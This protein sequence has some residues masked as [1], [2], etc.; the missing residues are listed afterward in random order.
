MVVGGMS[1]GV[2]ARCVADG[3]V[4]FRFP[5]FWRCIKASL[6]GVVCCLVCAYAHDECLLRC[7][8]T[9]EGPRLV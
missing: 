6:V 5:L 9:P 8:S 1:I 7:F 2:G 3:G 4:G